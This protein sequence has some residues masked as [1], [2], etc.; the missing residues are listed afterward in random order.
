M[1]VKST[2]HA[3]TVHSC[4]E[5]LGLQHINYNTLNPGALSPFSFPLSI[6]RNPASPNSFY[7]SLEVPA[8]ITP[9]AR[10]VEQALDAADSA[11]GD[12]LI[13]EFPVGEVHNILLGDAVNNLLNLQRAHATAGSDDLAANVLGNS[14]GAI[15]R[16]QDRGLELGLG[17][18][19]LGRRDV[20]RQARP[21]AEGEVDQV[22]DPAELVSDEVD[23]PEP[24]IG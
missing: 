21:L 17:T 2:P 16:Q 6:P 7:N 11:D 18:L 19:N 14:G 24:M 4:V 20:A 12:V 9:D 10:I 5:D 3:P 1:V 13:P 8:H 23:S 22:V 15:Q